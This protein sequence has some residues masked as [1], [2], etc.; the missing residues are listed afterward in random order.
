MKRSERILLTIFGFIFLIIV[1][2]GLLAFGIQSYRGIQTEAD[3]LR[4]RIVEMKDAISQGSEWQRRSE[5]LDA[6]VP[7]FT[8]R[9]EAS[10]R[11]LEM[12]QKEADKSAL[13]IGGKEF[14]EEVK[15]LAQDGLPVDATA[16]TNCRG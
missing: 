13:T 16:R 2:G 12:I 5:W 11:L 8:S 14:V 15:Q 10:T 3:G 7:S 4:K 1:G 6:N 9:Q